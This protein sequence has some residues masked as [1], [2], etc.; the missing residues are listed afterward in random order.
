MMLT[1]QLES[2]MRDTQFPTKREK[3]IV[4]EVQSAGRSC[5]ELVTNQ[6]CV[7]RR[8]THIWFFNAMVKTIEK[9][10]T[11]EIENGGLSLPGQ[12]QVEVVKTVR[13]TVDNST[14]IELK[15]CM[16]ACKHLPTLRKAWATT[17][18]AD[19]FRRRRSHGPETDGVHPPF[20]ALIPKEKDEDV[21][22][23]QTYHATLWSRCIGGE[24]FPRGTMVRRFLTKE[25]SQASQ[26]EITFC[27]KNT[28]KME[29]QAKKCL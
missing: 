6:P 15:A 27:A 29:E 19:H 2:R 14:F 20:C 11:D 21:R 23:D 28:R 18:V 12:V 16:K 13:T 9:T 4:K 25:A 1:V 3:D 24:S 17:Q 8:S 10:L 26:M 5:N 22:L 7:E